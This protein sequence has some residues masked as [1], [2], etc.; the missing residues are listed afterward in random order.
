MKYFK[1][2][3]KRALKLLNRY[4]FSF[5]KCELPLFMPQQKSVQLKAVAKK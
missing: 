3:Q 4:F 5:H 2:N 1:N